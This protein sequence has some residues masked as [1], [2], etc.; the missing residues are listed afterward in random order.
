MGAADVCERV[1]P[2][3][4]WPTQVIDAFADGDWKF[5]FSNGR[6]LLLVAEGVGARLLTWVG[7]L[8]VP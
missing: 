7:K 5:G 2:I 6:V 4:R 1:P 8:A 3:D